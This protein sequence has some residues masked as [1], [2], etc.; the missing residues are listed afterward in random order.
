[1]SRSR[2][3]L[4]GRRSLARA[5]RWRRWWNPVSA[6]SGWKASAKR[7]MGRLIGLCRSFSR[8]NLSGL[9]LDLRDNR[10]GLLSS[11]V[12]VA[13]RFLPKGQTIVSHR[14]RAVDREIVSGPSGS[15]GKPVPD[16]CAGQLRIR[17]GI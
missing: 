5:F 11:G 2:S 17:L 3:K 6:I 14:G 13:D 12:Q 9:I 16:G 10:G 1:M 15:Q 8:E 7:R 4:S